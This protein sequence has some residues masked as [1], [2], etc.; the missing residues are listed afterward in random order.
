MVEGAPGGVGGEA[1]GGAE[2]CGQGLPAPDRLRR[3]P[4]GAAPA[5]AALLTTAGGTTA[6]GVLPAARRGERRSWSVSSTS[7]R[8][9][10]E[11]ADMI[12]QFFGRCAR[13][14]CRGCCNLLLLEGV[15]RGVDILYI[16]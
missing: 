3:A 1:R 2:E 16:Y 5:A 10:G 4:V 15:G 12:I 7:P 11:F 9:V 14:E 8:G 13:S 6:F